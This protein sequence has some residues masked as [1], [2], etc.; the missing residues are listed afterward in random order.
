MK[1]R[2]TITDDCTITLTNF[3][4]DGNGIDVR[5]YGALGKDFVRGFPI[6]GQ[7]S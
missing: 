4:Y 3:F 6:G 5:F 2:A 7:Q 1:G